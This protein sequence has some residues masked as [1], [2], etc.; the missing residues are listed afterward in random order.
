MMLKFQEI[1]EH[2]IK[3]KPKFEKYFEK[4]GLNPEEI[5]NIKKFLEEL[6]QK[7]GCFW[8][9]GYCRYTPEFLE[10]AK[11]I[12]RNSE[13][14][15]EDIRIRNYEGGHFFLVAFLRDGKEFI[16]DPT[17]VPSVSG[18]GRSIFP[19]DIKPYFGLIDYATG[20]HKLIYENSV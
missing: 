8:K 17:G 14:Y 15:F 16:I 12:L 10:A 11:K 13:N 20:Y 4:R 5:K 1:F 6:Y 19:D 7:T 18:K 2:L 9:P 3:K